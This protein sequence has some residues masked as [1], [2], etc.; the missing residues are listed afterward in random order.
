MQQEINQV[1]ETADGLVFMTI[2]YPPEDIAS[3]I[4]NVYRI[5]AERES[6][7][8]PTQLLATNDTLRVLWAS[9]SGHLWVGSADGRVGTTAPVGWGAPGGGLE[10][11]T[12]AGPAWS[13]TALPRLR[14]EGIAPNVTAIW[15]SGDDD[16]HVGTHGGHLYHWDGKAWT[17]TR[18]GDGTGYQTIRAVRGQGRDDVFAVGA[19]GTLLHF[20]GAGW[21]NL[22]VPGGPNGG[23][24]LNGIACL[25]DGTT[26]ICATGDQGRLLHGNAQGFT[27]LGRYAVQLVD[28]AAVGDR[29]VF[30]TGNGVA[31]LSGRDVR[32][33]KET[34]QTSAAIAGRGRAFFTEPAAPGP[35]FIELDPRNA[36]A[37][38]WRY[39]F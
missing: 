27:E 24:A 8:L 34:F 39:T 32:M 28:I 4:G 14:N 35:Q 30:A 20:D 2:V 38:W 19:R 10:Y 23:D 16:V 33:I 1:V 7:D 21:R 3:A 25:D 17:Q 29:V 9:P 5:P 12:L 37:P 26:L 36:E 18:D 11:Q 13:A 31:E 6:E 15:G 22:P